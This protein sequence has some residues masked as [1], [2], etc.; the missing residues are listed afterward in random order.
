MWAAGGGRGKGEESKEILNSFTRKT[1]HRV[2][3]ALSSVPLVT[4]EENKIQSG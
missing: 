2:L 1:Q 4:V 3:L